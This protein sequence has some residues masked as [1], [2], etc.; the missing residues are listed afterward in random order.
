VNRFLIVGFGVSQV[1]IVRIRGNY[2]ACNQAIFAEAI[3]C[4]VMPALEVQAAIFD[5]AA[6]DVC[7]GECSETVDDRFATLLAPR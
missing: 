4:F 1:T 6:I 7:C 3:H 2:F 5:E